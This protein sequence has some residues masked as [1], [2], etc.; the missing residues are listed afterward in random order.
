[1]A[2]QYIEE[3]NTFPT[4]KVFMDFIA[5]EDKYVTE[6]VTSFQSIGSHK[7]NNKL[8]TAMQMT[9]GQNMHL[10]AITDC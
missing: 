1:M 3:T 8:Q 5:R 9:T 4:F 7:D 10:A 6:P 2:T